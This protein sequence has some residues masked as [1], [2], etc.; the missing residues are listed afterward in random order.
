M[1]CGAGMGPL[2]KGILQCAV[3]ALWAVWA[4]AAAAQQDDPC[5]AYTMQSVVGLE[6]PGRSID[7]PNGPA[8]QFFRLSPDTVVSVDDQGFFTGAD[9][10]RPQC[11]M[12]HFDGVRCFLRQ[13]PPG[14]FLFANGFHAV[15]VAGTCPYNMVFDGVNCFW[16]RAP[17]GTR[18][19]SEAGNWYITPRGSCVVPQ[20]GPK[21]DPLPDRILGAFDGAVC[22]VANLSTAP[23][24]H[25]VLETEQGFFAVALQPSPG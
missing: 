23:T 13:A 17:F 8:C 19:L 16:R 24:R 12:G 4:T 20:F 11:P 25:L 1:Q 2:K 5:A 9:F 14:A 15:P 22:R 21:G 18:A 7:T 10:S 6:V 3:A